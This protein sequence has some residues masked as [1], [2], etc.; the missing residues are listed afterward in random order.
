MKAIFPRLATGETFPAAERIR[1][2]MPRAGRLVVAI[3]AAG[4]GLMGRAVM[5]ALGLWRLMVTRCR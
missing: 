5:I 1:R 3:A 2:P 4:G